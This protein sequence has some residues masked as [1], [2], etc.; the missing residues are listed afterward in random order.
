MEKNSSL[1]AKENWI[2]AISLLTHCLYVNYSK[3]FAS[4]Q[5]TFDLLMMNETRVPCG[6]SGTQD[7]FCCVMEITLDTN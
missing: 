6:E 2:D 4:S 7:W 5:L 3:M 1:I